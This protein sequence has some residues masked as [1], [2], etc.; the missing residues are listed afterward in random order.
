VRSANLYSPPA[1]VCPNG[2][3]GWTQVPLMQD[4]PF[5]ARQAYPD[6]V[7]FARVAR[8]KTEYPDRLDDGGFRSDWRRG[9]ARRGA[10]WRSAASV[11]KGVGSNP[12][13]V[14]AGAQ[15]PE[16]PPCRRRRR[17]PRRPARASRPRN[18]E[19]ARYRGDKSAACP[20]KKR[21]PWG[22]SPRPRG[23]CSLLTELSGLSA[24]LDVV[25]ISYD[26]R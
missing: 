10:A 20:Q 26:S 25:I 4:A 22:S 15:T 17:C 3:R 2:L 9:A 14:I 5:V 23:P 21:P 8:A 13:A 19:A 1:R 7:A 11:R 6:D 16:Q 12:T 18:L 24:I